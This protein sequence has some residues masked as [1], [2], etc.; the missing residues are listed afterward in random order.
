[1]SRFEPAEVSRVTVTDRAGKSREGDAKQ[2]AAVA[3][4]VATLVAKRVETPAAMPEDFARCGLS[5]P[6]YRVVLDFGAAGGAARKNLLVGD[7]APDGC[8]YVSAGG[9]D[10][11]IF[12]VQPEKLAA[13][14]DFLKTANE[15]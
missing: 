10:A 11:A 12:V 2:S 14:A 7:A 8:L 5:K 6:A 3:D 1:M 15:E 13:I 9:V 4:A